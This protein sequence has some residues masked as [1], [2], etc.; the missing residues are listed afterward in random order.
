[1]DVEGQRVK[2]YVRA[3]A[4]RGSRSLSNGGKTAVDSQWHREAHWVGIN[5]RSF[6]YGSLTFCNPLV[7]SS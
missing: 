3:K 7:G 1:M 5:A 4:A 2:S 6:K